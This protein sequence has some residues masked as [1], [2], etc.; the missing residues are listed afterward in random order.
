[1]EIAY[2]GMGSNLDSPA[3][4]PEATLA[5]AAVRLESLGRMI[6]RSSLYSTEP[7]GFRDQ[8]R[9]LN[10]VMALE[11]GLDPRSLL[12]GLLEI[13]KEFGRDRSAGIPNGPRTLDLDI[14]VYGNERI[15][16]PGLEIPHPRMG[17]R[18]FVVIPL[19]ELASNDE[20][21]RMPEILRTLLRTS[22]PF[23]P[24]QS[25]AVVR[26]QSDVWRARRIAADSG[27]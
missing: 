27:G 18:A 13:E 3:G 4:G 16:E 17:E 9:F 22:H 23:S 7:V 14:L 5:A 10:A 6:G 20:A 11:T 12:Q 26:V 24:G 1:M 19:A 2:I 25:H 15:S 8:P 21:G